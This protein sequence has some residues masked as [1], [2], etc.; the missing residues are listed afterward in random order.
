[1]WNIVEEIYST[2]DDAATPELTPP[3]KQ[4]VIETLDNY[5]LAFVVKNHLMASNETDVGETV[6]YEI[7]RA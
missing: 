2:P 5:D 6:F 7:A 3:I 4:V 1:M